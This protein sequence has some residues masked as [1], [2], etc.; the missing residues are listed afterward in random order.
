MLMTSFP[1]SI[2]W[3]GCLFSMG[4][5]FLLCPRLIG[6]IVMDRNEGSNKMSILGRDPDTYYGQMLNVW[7]LRSIIYHCHNTNRVDWIGG[8]LD[9]SKIWDSYYNCITKALVDRF[10]KMSTC[11]MGIIVSEHKNLLDS[12]IVKLLYFKFMI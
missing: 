12:F 11:C 8:I 2:C 1:N 10:L 7:E 3:R 5:S 6:H 4:Y 9:T